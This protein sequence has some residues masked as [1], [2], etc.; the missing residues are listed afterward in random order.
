MHKISLSLRVGLCEQRFY[1][2]LDNIVE[3][4]KFF[5]C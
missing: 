1:V 4:S 2:F 3:N 5:D